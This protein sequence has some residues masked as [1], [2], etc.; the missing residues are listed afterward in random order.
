MVAPAAFAL[1]FCA[2]EAARRFDVPLGFCL[3]QRLLGMRCPG[4]GI[5]RSIAALM[6]GDVRTA[7]ALNLAG[8]VVLLYF[9]IGSWC[10][11][12]AVR[13]PHMQQQLLM[14]NRRNEQGLLFGLLGA[15]VCHLIID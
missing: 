8:P 13:R 11:A 3:A 4:C 9:L 6:R 2:S 7:I 12:A 14:W 10:V 5:T 15:W 1:I